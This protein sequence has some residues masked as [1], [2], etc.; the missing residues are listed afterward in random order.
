MYPGVYTVVQVL[1]LTSNEKLKE[2]LREVLKVLIYF[3]YSFIP[4]QEYGKYLLCTKL[5]SCDLSYRSS[6]NIKQ[7]CPSS[8]MLM[9]GQEADR[10]SPMSL[11]S[12]LFLV[13]LI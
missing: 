5:C 9:E 13:I 11:I 1:L 2:N 8:N 4:S 7:T 3:I 12:D 6:F 10:P